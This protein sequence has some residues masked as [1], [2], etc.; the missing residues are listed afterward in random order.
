[1][2]GSLFATPIINQP[3]TGILGVGR[4]QKRVVVLEGDAIAVR[5]MVYLTLTFD[6]RVLDG[7]S[8]DR[9]MRVVKRMLE[10]WS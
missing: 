8:G 2:S 10:G 7:A 1:V 3:Q 4:V 6:H 9:F 5:P